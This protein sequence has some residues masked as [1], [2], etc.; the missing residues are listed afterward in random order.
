MQSLNDKFSGFKQEIK[1]KLKHDPNIV[2][3]GRDLRTGEVKKREMGA[4]NTLL[5]FLSDH[6]S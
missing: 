3:H 5:L 4:V 2:E 1:G 6:L